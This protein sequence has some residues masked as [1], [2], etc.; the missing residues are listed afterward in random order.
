MKKTLL[1]I[2]SVLFTA[3]VLLTSCTFDK[4][5]SKEPVLDF[6]APVF[7]G[8]EIFIASQDTTK[9][10]TQ[11][12][13]MGDSKTGKFI[14]NQY[15]G[16]SQNSSKSD[17]SLGF[18]DVSD[19][20]YNTTT[21]IAK[22]ESGEGS[23]TFLQFIVDDTNSP[24]LVF[25][26]IFYRSE[27]ESGLYT[28]FSTKDG[29]ASFTFLKNGKVEYAEGAKMTTWKYVNNDGIITVKDSQGSARNFYYYSNGMICFADAIHTLTKQD[30]IKVGV[31]DFK[32]KGSPKYLTRDIPEDS[33]LD[34]LEVA[35][36]DLPKEAKKTICIADKGGWSSSYLSGTY[37]D[38]QDHLKKYDSKQSHIYLDFDSKFG[39]GGFYEDIGE[40]YFAGLTCLEGVILRKSS[41]KSGNINAA[42]EVFKNCSNLKYVYISDD[43]TQIGPFSFEGCTALKEVEFE[44]PSKWNI[45]GEPGSSNPEENAEH[46]RKH[47][48]N[49][50]DQED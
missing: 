39:F 36:R 45:A 6:V 12:V 33:Q 11:Y 50:I 3:L 5:G 24:A 25:S 44:T 48:D 34:Y 32:S 27:N 10:I 15:V 30:E 16:Y 2:T 49:G 19:Y 20:E 18:L 4:T 43:F 29:Q 21:G 42:A 9:G 38:I 40:A 46:I 41:N 31:K 14:N 22:W 26:P 47:V 13:Y 35:L 37:K 28:C 1:T 8:G 7:E 17:Q 23:Y